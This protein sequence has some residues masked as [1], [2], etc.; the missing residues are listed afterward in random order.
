MSTGSSDPR[1]SFIKRALLSRL[2]AG[3]LP[4]PVAAALHRRLAR[5]PE[6]LAAYEALRRAERAAAGGP[7]I[8]EQQMALFERLVVEQAAT[9]A[10]A[11]AP[12]GALVG[13]AAAAAAVALF[14][15]LPRGEDEWATRSAAAAGTKVG[16]RVRCLSVTSAAP[17]V[18]SESVLSPHRAPASLACPREAMLAFSV[19][20]LD[21]EP[22]HVF[23]VGVNDRDELRWYAPFEPSSRSVEVRAGE[24]DR[25]LETLAELRDLPEGER[26]TVFALFS[27]DPVDGAALEAR[28][29]EARARGLP[30]SRL[31]RL[32]VGVELQARADLISSREPTR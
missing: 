22:R 1:L 26:V 6:W 3:T 30:L 11:R 5:D 15:A 17:R 7:V 28:L 25:L 27:D 10:E 19:T 21:D 24:V 9:G 2:V 32:P 16:V 4:R 8:T 14:L 18:V 12:R 13:L 23:L 31:D 29:R 20:N